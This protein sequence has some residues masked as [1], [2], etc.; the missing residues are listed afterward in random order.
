[1]QNP[2]SLLGL[3]W[4]Y[5][6]LV[7]SEWEAFTNSMDVKDNCQ[8]RSLFPGR[9]PDAGEGQDWTP[10]LSCPRQTRWHANLKHNQLNQ[11]SMIKMMIDQVSQCS[12]GA[13]GQRWTGNYSIPSIKHNPGLPRSYFVRSP[14]GCE[15]L[16]KCQKGPES[17]PYLCYWPHWEQEKIYKS[18]GPTFLLLTIRACF[19]SGFVPLALNQWYIVHLVF[20]Y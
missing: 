11:W 20:V 1:M 17:E 10:R 8:L 5:G 2:H 7:N 9:A 18:T 4:N 13:T 3:V 16:G 6:S 14:R 15:A 19:T 12:T